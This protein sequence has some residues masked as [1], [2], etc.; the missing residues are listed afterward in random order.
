MRTGPIGTENYIRTQI[1]RT[2]TY[3]FAG[4]GAVIIGTFAHFVL[5]GVPNTIASD[6][7]LCSRLFR[8]LLCDSLLERPSS[9]LV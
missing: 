8:R 7:S 6:A 1:M 2:N 9:S 4:V 3:I 5:G